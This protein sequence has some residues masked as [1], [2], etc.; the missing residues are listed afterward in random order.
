MPLQIQSLSCTY[1]QVILYK[2][3]I[4]YEK[5]LSTNAVFTAIKG[6]ILKQFFKSAGGGGQQVYPMNLLSVF[7]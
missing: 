1:L 4:T 6:E 7:L 3:S 5:E 2:V